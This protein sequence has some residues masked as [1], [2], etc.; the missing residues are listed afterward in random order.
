MCG[1]SIRC[2]A[3]YVAASSSRGAGDAATYS[4]STLAGPIVPELLPDGQIKVDMG[5][6]ILNGAD[7]RR[8][9]PATPTAAWWSSRSRWRGRSGR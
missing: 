6:P 2:M 7:V 1:N 5:E 4:I 3:R 8:R 9:S